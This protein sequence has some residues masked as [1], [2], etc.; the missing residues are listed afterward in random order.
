MPD[1][2]TAEFYAKLVAEHSRDSIMVM[3]ARGV[4]QWVNAGCLRVAGMSREDMVGKR[5]DDLFGTRATSVSAAERTYAVAVSPSSTTLSARGN[6]RHFRRTASRSPCI[7]WKS[8]ASSST[9]AHSS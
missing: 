8:K 9:P 5:P 7:T 1:A 4:V 3:D 6:H 2:P